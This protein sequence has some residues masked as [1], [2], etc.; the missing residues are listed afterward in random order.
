M[1]RALFLLVAGLF[2]PTVYAQNSL[3]TEGLG[4]QFVPQEQTTKLYCEHSS[5]TASYTIPTEETLSISG[6]EGTSEVLE[7]QEC[8]STESQK[9]I[10]RPNVRISRYR[11]YYQGELAFAYGLAVGTSS[12]YSRLVFETV[13]GVRINPL[14]I[15][16]GR[17]C[18]QSLLQRSNYS[19]RIL[20]NTKR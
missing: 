17:T 19:R 11:S 16:W 6:I 2:I 9:G 8:I 7:P 20:G 4:S 10:N 15:Y 1:K 14:C 3:I 12:D 5:A 13:H 18:Y